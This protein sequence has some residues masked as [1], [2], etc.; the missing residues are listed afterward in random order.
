M[1]DD[2]SDIQ[3]FYDRAVEQE[4]GRL[5]R[6]QLERDI[7]WCYLD[8]YLPLQ[9]NILDI[10]AATG[11]YT[12]PLAKRGY[13]VT[14]VDLSP[15]LIEVCKKRVAE[16]GLEE[17]VTCHVADARNLTG[18]PGTKF[19][20]VL[21]MG[22]LYHLILEEDRKKALQEAFKRLK[23]GGVIFSVFISRYGIW[24]NVMKKLPDYIE[25]QP[26]LQSV[27]KEG[28]DAD[29]EYWKGHFRGYFATVPEIVPLHEKIG[30]KTL[31]LAG[32]E[33]A[34]VDD[35]I[36]NSIQ[37]TNRQ[38]WLDLLFSISTEKSIIGASN[39]I[40]YIGVKEG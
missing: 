9:G 31:V 30:F 22:P 10:G 26:D 8:K 4:N 33:P 18:V 34:G 35:Q 2:I 3:A 19:D 38:L 6:R 28:K 37:G 1:A 24:G 17:K 14:T 36:Y 11:A 20:A 27:L 16:E 39:H 25:R 23:T 15:K 40:M 21:M 12:I 32:V 7:T 29:I 13:G 5:Q